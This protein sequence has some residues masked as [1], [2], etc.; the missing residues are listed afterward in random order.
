MA[1][2]SIIVF[3]AGFRA[4]PVW[5]VPRLQPDDVLWVG[6]CGGGG[7][8]HARHRPRPHRL[9]Q[10]QPGLRHGAGP[11]PALQRL[12]P[13]RVHAA[14]VTGRPTYTYNFLGTVQVLR[15][16]LLFYI[17]Y[18]KCLKLYDVIL[19]QSLIHSIKGPC[20][21]CLRQLNSQYSKVK[22]LVEFLFHPKI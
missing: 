17:M 5:R 11:P 6:G 18:I 16:P 15:H 3:V 10:P 22:Q 21:H 7:A 14:G 12:I 2:T 1:Y 4:R 8:G 9:P 13:P 20:Q 19:E